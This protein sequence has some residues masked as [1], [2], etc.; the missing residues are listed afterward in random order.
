VVI[1]VD[2]NVF[3]RAIVEP[4]T[5]DY[6]LMSNQARELFRRAANGEVE[7]ITSE[8]HIAE[9]IFILSAKGRYGVPADR[10]AGI[11]SVLLSE[12]RIKFSNKHIVLEALDVWAKRPSIGFHDAVAVVHSRQPDVQLATFDY[13]LRRMAGVNV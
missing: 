6:I 8:A 1:F 3:V 5:P 4:T 12:T 10:C 11:M 9:T 7:L 2:T 13:A